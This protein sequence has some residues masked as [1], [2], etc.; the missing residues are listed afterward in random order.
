MFDGQIMG[1][2]LPQNT[3]ERELGLWMAGVKEEAN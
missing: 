3:D 2:R 1:E